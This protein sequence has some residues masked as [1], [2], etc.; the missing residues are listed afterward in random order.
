MTFS[1]NIALFIFFCQ[2]L[3]YGVKGLVGFGNP[4]VSSPILSMRLD[5]IIIT[6]GTLLLDFPINLY[7]AWKNRKNF[8]WTRM[9]PLL[10]AT[11][12]GAVPG[13]LLLRFSLPWVIKT[14]L[15]IVVLFIGIEMATR[16]LQPK[17]ELRKL[18]GLD[19]AVAL[20]SGICA[21]LFGINMILVGYLQR[22]ARDYNEFKGSICF[23]FLGDNLFRLCSYAFN[24]LMTREVLFFGGASVPAALLAMLLAGWLGPK[25]EEVKL[26]KG[27]IA[28]FILGGI[29]IIV[30]SAIFHT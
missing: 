27:A 18:P 13:T 28:L 9:L 15:G 3:G 2:F 4:L 20:I 21:G 11:V 8:Q 6:P 24:G 30:K 14:L 23:L 19:L 12:C 17:R 5:N 22:T 16:N 7:L 25:L 1:W 10:L 29:S 26:Q